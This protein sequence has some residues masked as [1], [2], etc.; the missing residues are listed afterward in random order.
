MAYF[1]LLLVWLA[2]RMLNVARL[3]PRVPKRSATGGAWPTQVFSQEEGFWAFPLRLTA[4]YSVHTPVLGVLGDLAHRLTGLQDL[5]LRDDDVGQ[6]GVV[7]PLALGAAGH[8]HP[9]T[10]GAGLEQVDRAGVGGADGGT[11]GGPDVGPGVVLPLV[12]R[13]LTV[14]LPT[15]GYITLGGLTLRYWGAACPA[16]AVEGISSGAQATPRTTSPARARISDLERCAV[17]SACLPRKTNPV[18]YRTWAVCTNF[19]VAWGRCENNALAI[20]FVGACNPDPRSP[21][22]FAA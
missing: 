13:S 11:A 7:A 3:K 5:S 2:P 12:P 20:G 15:T 19:W 16:A 4:K 18:V 6:V 17:I 1:E 10:R 21:G 8:A 14:L 22:R 9:L